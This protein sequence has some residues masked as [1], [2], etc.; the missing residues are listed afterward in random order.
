MLYIP[1]DDKEYD[2]V[3]FVT[4]LG[5]YNK[6]EFANAQRLHEI[7]THPVSYESYPEY[8]TIT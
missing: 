1:T 4:Y 3:Y 8:E 5:N 7:D 2:H 6:Q